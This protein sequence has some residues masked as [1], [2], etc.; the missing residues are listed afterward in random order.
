MI[1]TNRKLTEDPSPLQI[2]VRVFPLT[3]DKPDR[4]PR[5]FW[6]LPGAMLVFDTES[7]TDPRQSLTFG[8]YQYR[9][10][11]HNPGSFYEAL[12][13]GNSL[14]AAEL[15]TLR[16]YVKRDKSFFGLY[17]E[18][19]DD[20]LRS[21]YMDGYKYR[22]L[23]VAFNH[24]FDLSRIAHDF[25]F[26]RG[27]HYSGGFSLG[28]WT[29]QKNGS[30]CRN[31]HR[32]RVCVKHIDS[33]RALI[34]FTARMNADPEDRIPE[35]S[36]DGK[37]K[38]DYVFR[39]H[40]LDLRTLAYALTDQAH[41]LESA[42]RAFGV[43]HGKQKANRHGKVTSRYITYNRRDVLATV[44][45][46]YKLLE[47]YAKHPIS[48]QATRAFSP[49]SIGKGYLR[50]MGIEPVLSR[51]PN[52]PKK[53][54]GFAQ[55]AFYGG[56]TSAHIRKVP[57]PVVFTD[58]LSMYPT[59]NSLM[60]LWQFVIAS[61]VRVI[62]NQRRIV[63]RQ[64]KRWQLSDF[65]KPETWRHFTC[66]VRIVPDGD[67]LPSRG[68]FSV[69]SNDWQV[70]LNY[71]YAGNR[72]SRHGLWYSLPDAA[73]SMLLTGKVPKIVDAFR[74]E[75]QG[76]LGG[77]KP[78][79]LRG[80][81]PVDPSKQDFF[82]TVIEQRAILARQPSDDE[83]EKKRLNRALK[84]LANAAS[85]GIYAEMIRQESEKKIS[86]PCQG[87]YSRRYLCKPTAHV[88]KPGAYCFPPLAS[89]ITGAARLMLASWNAA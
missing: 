54:L 23:I 60:G 15:Q 1:E 48:L 31:P 65:F 66:F 50:E 11:R 84:V 46:A 36:E 12:F 62:P 28:L 5:K 69:E 49:A 47:E 78:T 10:L 33:K 18:T 58:F 43:E 17:L 88:E 56:R 86:V 68:R 32:P 79:S 74:L 37:P 72:Q 52:F 38:S 63:E 27:R 75:A 24:P 44:E 53:I 30:R 67:I 55:S 21:M 81:I 51:Q 42:C 26:A 22:S 20:F 76:I 4:K 73:A 35:G 29:Y 6:R 16:R 64:L 89:L 87:I 9:R 14:Q 7:R 8:S 45:L 77:L 61:K 80:E 85:Y 25:A 39:G 70:A 34:G 71:L 2:A 41:S 83:A 19:L 82:K 40:F 59:V 13:F 3:A 57:V